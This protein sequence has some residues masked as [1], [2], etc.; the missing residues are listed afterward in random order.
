MK[1]SGSGSGR[2]ESWSI[3]ERYSFFLPGCRNLGISS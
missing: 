2:G 1:W 3:N